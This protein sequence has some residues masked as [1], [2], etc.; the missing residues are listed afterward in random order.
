MKVIEYFK[1]SEFGAWIFMDLAQSSP[2]D[3]L[4]EKWL[5]GEGGE[6]GGRRE[7]WKG[8]EDGAMRAPRDVWMFWLFLIS[9]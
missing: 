3:G 9:K 8:G 1:P 7:V 4:S 5:G 2:E 6:G